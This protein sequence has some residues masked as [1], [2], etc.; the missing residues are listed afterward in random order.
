M[1]LQERQS[2]SRKADIKGVIIKS[3]VG[4]ILRVGVFRVFFKYI[5]NIDIGRLSVIDS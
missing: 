4:V 1:F 2:Y 5:T 3:E